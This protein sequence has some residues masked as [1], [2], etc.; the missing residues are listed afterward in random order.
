MLFLSMNAVLLELA[1]TS[2][3]CATPFRESVSKQTPKDFAIPNTCTTINHRKSWNALTVKERHEYIEAELCLMHHPPVTGLVENATNVWDE[4]ANIHISQ[5]NDIHYVGQFLPWHRYSVRMHEL[6]L[7]K[8][9]NY[10]GAH[11]YWDELTDYTNGN[12]SQSPI[13]DPITGFGGN[14]TGYDGCVVNGPFGKIKLHM[15]LHHARGNEFC[16]S[17]NLDQSS[18]AEGI[19]TNVEHCFGFANYTDSW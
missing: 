17:R 4:I 1:I 19:A 2:V 15:S 16:L 9:C 5:R 7:Q 6:A 14:G 10:R 13:F 8:L 12:V 18:F 3:V 11:P